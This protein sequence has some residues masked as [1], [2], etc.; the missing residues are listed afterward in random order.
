[1]TD[2]TDKSVCYTFLIIPGRL[3][4]PLSSPV[5]CSFVFTLIRLEIANNKFINTIATSIRNCVRRIR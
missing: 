2:E 4:A 1:M 5:A 3:L